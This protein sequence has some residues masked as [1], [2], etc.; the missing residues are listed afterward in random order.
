MQP[1]LARDAGFAL[2]I[3]GL[4]GM[5]SGLFGARALR[6]RRLARSGAAQQAPTAWASPSV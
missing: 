4:Y 5:F 6:L 1:S 2:Q 3:A